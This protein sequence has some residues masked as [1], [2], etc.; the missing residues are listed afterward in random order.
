MRDDRAE[1][2][3]RIAGELEAAQRDPDRRCCRAPALLRDDPRVDLA[4]A[5]T[6]AREVGGDLYDYFPPRRAS[7]VLPRSAT[8]R[9]K[10]L[11]GRAS[12]WR[13]A[14]RCTR[15]RRCARQ[16]TDIGALMSAANAEVSRDNPEMLFVTAFAG[17]LDLET[18][19]LAYC[20]AGHE[21]PYVLSAAIGRMEANRRRR[22]ARRRAPWTTIPTGG[23]CRLQPGDIVCVVTDG[24]Q[25]RGARRGELYGR[26]A[27]ETMP[28]CGACGTARIADRRSVG[29]VVRTTRTAFRRRR[30]AAGRPH[31]PGSCVWN[32]PWRRLH[33]ARG[34]SLD[35]PLASAYVQSP[36]GGCA[37]PA[38]PSGVGTDGLAL[39]PRPNATMFSGATPRRISSA[40]TVVGALAR[41][42]I[43]DRVAAERVSVADDDDVR[44]R[45]PRDLSEDTVDDRA[46]IL[47]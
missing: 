5:M 40:R 8:S 39:L 10:R 37:A 15:A 24:G 30:R 20:N 22:H 26:D 25:R 35:S 12:S 23:E 28:A 13:S 41:E 46:S 44:H 1:Q 2:A 38:T 32:G 6:P 33:V 11:V 4:A 17:I 34:W 16:D 19:E 43:V 18:G 7:A 31:G 27:R 29:T 3:A 45:P 9:R 36:R 21:N 42:R 47:R 14:R